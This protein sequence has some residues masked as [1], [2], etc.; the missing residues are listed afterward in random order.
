MKNK[1]ILLIILL[2]GLVLNIFPQQKFRRALLLS[3]SVG[4]HIW[5]HQGATTSVPEEIISYNTANYYNGA[6]AVSMEKIYPYPTIGNEW[7]DWHIV[8]DN[9]A[10]DSYLDDQNYDI[11]ILKTCYFSSDIY[12]GWGNPA[13]TT[14]N[15]TRRTVS[16]YKWAWRS[17][18]TKMAAHPEK[19]FVIWTNPPRLKSKTTSQQATLSNAFCTW[20]KDTLAAGLDVTYGAF[21]SNVYVFD[22]FHLVDSSYY[23]PVALA[24]GGPDEDHPNATCSELVAPIFVK[25]VFDAAIFYESIIPVELTLFSASINSNIIE[26]KWQTASELNNFGFEIQRS[27]EN[28]QWQKVGFVHGNGT[29]SI[30]N[31]YSFSDQIKYVQG[32]YYYRLKQIDHD[33][34]YEFSNIV[35]V[36][37]NVPLK[38][39]LEQ[40]YPNPFNPSTEI[41]FTL[42]KSGV[43][44]LKIYNSLGSEVSS[45]V[46]GFMNSGVH[47]VRFNAKGFASGIYYYRIVAD[48][49]TSTRKMLLIR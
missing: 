43:V 24:D 48:K 23:L 12:G 6:D 18:L 3:R 9:G 42:A 32:R 10:I 31:N 37:F 25:E 45:L 2:I 4:N 35:E 13:D 26:L 19:F 16:L 29:S 38:T 36:D 1:K 11:L 20:A 17:I 7:N 47:S 15:L 28:S 14:E 46:D 49:Y 39:E 41:N 33:G 44:Y 30:L 40:N 27:S 22:Y 5:D 8:F 21:P 34:T